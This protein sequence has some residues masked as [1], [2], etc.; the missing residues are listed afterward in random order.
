[1]ALIKNESGEIKCIDER[2]NTMWF[3]PIIAN[4]ERLMKQQGMTV[5]NSPEIL[6]PKIKDEHFYPSKEEQ[7]EINAELLGLKEPTP[8]PPANTDVCEDKKDQPRNK[9]IAVKIKKEK[10]AK[11]AKANK[12]N[13]TKK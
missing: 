9:V 7:I 12:S 1:M 13:K 8:E 3:A 6:L 5:F 2:G 11:V 4:D 10:T